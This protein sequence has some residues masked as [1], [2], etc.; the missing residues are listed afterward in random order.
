MIPNFQDK[1]EKESLFTPEMGLKDRIKK[2]GKPNFPVPKG[3]IFCFNWD[4]LNYILENFENKQVE[5]F[6][7]KCYMLKEAPI[8]VVSKFGIGAP[9]A[10]ALIEDLIA[11]G[12]KNFVSIGNAGSLQHDVKVGDLVVVEKAIRDE[13]TSHHYITPSKY[14]EAPTGMLK[15]LK[16]VLSEKRIDFHAGTSWTTDAFFRE[17]IDEVKH[18]QKE[19]ILTVE[20]EAAALFS[21]AKYRSVNF[22]TLLSISD[23]LADLEWKPRWQAPEVHLAYKKLFDVAKE[24]ILKMN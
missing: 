20:M 22:C 9:V 4:L 6:F 21:V 13:G 3:V 5:G 18:Y 19:G 23:S 10:T 11:Y 14:V 24:V 1:Y 16:D 12:I 17:T 15:A 7:A 2:D 8:M